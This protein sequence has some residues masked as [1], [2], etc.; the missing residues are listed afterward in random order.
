MNSLYMSSLFANSFSNKI[1]M[2]WNREWNA[3]YI[4]FNLNLFNFYYICG[5][6]Y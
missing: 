4:L 6:S 5:A 1:K 3:C 2:E